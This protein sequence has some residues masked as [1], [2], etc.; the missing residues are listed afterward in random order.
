MHIYWTKINRIVDET[1][2][3]KTYYLDIPDKFSWEEGAFT[4]MGL[5][6]FNEGE[7]PN[8]GLVRHLSISTVPNEQEIGITTRIRQECSEF[9]QSLRQHKVGDKVALFK[10]HCNVPLRREN[11]N[12]YL[13]SAGVGSATFRPIA[14]Q[15]LS[16]Q[17]HINKVHSLNI[18]TSRDFIFT[19][20]FTTNTDKRFTTDF[21]SSRDDY[22]HKV[23]Q[24]AQDKDSI[25]YVVGSDEFLKDNIECLQRE[26]IANEQIMLDKR[27][28][29]RVEFFRT[30][31]NA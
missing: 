22:Y 20:V 28:S 12:I 25:F 17:S 31:Q 16:D 3:I 6:G 21:S 27:E 30:K 19:D 24:L 2:E 14:L 26:G 15:Y 13:L 1:D 10:I 9:K 8:R 18:D 5:K 29:Q 11:K 4:H 7:K 23:K